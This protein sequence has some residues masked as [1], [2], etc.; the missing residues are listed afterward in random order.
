MSRAVIISAFTGV[1]ALGTVLSMGMAPSHPG[2]PSSMPLKAEYRVRLTS[3]W[4]VYAGGSAQCNNRGSE[5]LE[6]TL[7]REG[8]GGY[9]GR[10]RRHTELGFCGAHGTAQPTRCGLRLSGDGPVDVVATMVADSAGQL[11][12]RWQADTGQTVVSVSGSCDQEFQRALEAMYLS[13]THSIELP[14]PAA[15]AGPMARILEDYGWKVEVE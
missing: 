2:G 12:L 9:R 11:R 6:G 1:A 15:G 3:A 10:F 13:A 7:A 8:I 14:V 5:V 4:P